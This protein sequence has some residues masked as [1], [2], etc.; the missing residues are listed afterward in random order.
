MN[1]DLKYSLIVFLLCFIFIGGIGNLI[2]L[3]APTS[4]DGEVIIK[5]VKCYDRYDN[6]IEGLDCIKEVQT[7]TENEKIIALIVTNL[8]LFVVSFFTSGLGWEIKYLH[9]ENRKPKL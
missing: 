1:E 8:V 9:E 7:M 5:E 4:L 3:S 2:M 6:E